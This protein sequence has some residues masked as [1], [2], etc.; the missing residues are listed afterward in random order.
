VKVTKFST[1]TLGQ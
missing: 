1:A